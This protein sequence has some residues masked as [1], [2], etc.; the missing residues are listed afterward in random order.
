MVVE[1]GVVEAG[2]TVARTRLWIAGRTPAEVCPPG[3]CP[4]DLRIDAVAPTGWASTEGG[5]NSNHAELRCGDDGRGGLGGYWL[6]PGITFDLGAIPPDTPIA[7]AVLHVWQVRVD[8]DSPF[9]PTMST[10]VT[11]HVRFTNMWEVD[12]V[13]AISGTIGQRVLSSTGDVGWREVDVTEVIEYELAA[14]RSRAQFRLRFSPNEAD[15]DT[16]IDWV[17]FASDN[18]VDVTLRPYLTIDY[19]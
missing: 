11:E 14:L 13:S 7:S 1:L 10:V 15:G 3:G 19:R 12:E 17:V 6:E 2:A 4:P 18:S 16:S 5:F 9:T 8:G